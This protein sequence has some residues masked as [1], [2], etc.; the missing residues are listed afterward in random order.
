MSASLDNRG[1]S[2][3]GSRS[4]NKCITI[5]VSTRPVESLPT[6]IIYALLFL[7]SFEFTFEALVQFPYIR[8]IDIPISILE[9]FVRFVAR[10]SLP[11]NKTIALTRVEAVKI[12]NR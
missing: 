12:S 8:N 7:S 3:D 9:S 5:E 1:H 6:T 10:C 2:G 11:T 4:T